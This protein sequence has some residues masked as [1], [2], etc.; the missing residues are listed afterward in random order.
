MKPNLILTGWHWPEYVA[1]AATALE[2]LK[3]KADIAGVSMN[4]LASVLAER[5]GDYRTVYV[6]GVGLTRNIA[7]TLSA[8]KTLKAKKIKMVY[9]SSMELAPEFAAELKLEGTRSAA[10]GFSEVQAEPCASLVDAVV[11]YFKTIDKESA[12]FYRAYAKPAGDRESAV[13]KYQTL[14]LAAGF[15]HRTCGNDSIYSDTIVALYE[16]VKP[17][18]WEAKLKEA[19]E[20]YIR[21]GRRELTGSSVMIDEVR[22]RVQK[23]AKY[24]R[25]RVLI[26]GESGT[27]KETIAQQ[28][29]MQSPRKQ[30]PF[31]AFNCAS[32]AKEL[33]E[34]KLFGH[35]VGAYTGADK[36]AKGLFEQADHGTLFL[37]EIAEMPLEA[38]ALVLRA[39]QDGVITRLGGVEEKRVDVRLVAATNQNLPKLVREGKF[40]ADLYQRLS[41][42]VITVPP[43][44]DRRKDIGEI[45]AGFWL[46]MGWGRLTEVQLKALAK[47]DYPGNVRELLNILDRARALEED[48][49]DKLLKEHI[50]INR[51]LWANETSTKAKTDY[52]EKLED[53]IRMHVKAVFEK[54]G[55]NL[56]ETEQALDVSRKTVKKYLGA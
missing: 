24:D 6:L 31:V 41:T 40:R 44:R 47:Y 50:E 18:L 9:I 20:D 5:G 14:I 3:G 38:Q 17:V 30:G 46:E 53:A 8:L 35:E 13:G 48:D 36:A 10:Q 34:N 32:V 26:L 23:I 27:G 42:V 25:A 51:D 29:H 33:L 16:R 11:S 4:R 43:L 12:D 56:A 22:K 49:F 1:A 21:Y 28:M 2:A 45:A 7:E 19:Y 55:R 39:T 15:L 52:P 37:D 54:H